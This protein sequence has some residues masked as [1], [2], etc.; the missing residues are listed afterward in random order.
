MTVPYLSRIFLSPMRR[1]TQQLLRNPQRLHAAVLAGVPEQPVCQRVLWRL[2]PDTAR[3]ATLL[4]LTQTLPSWAGLVEQAGW[5]DSEQPQAETRNLETL[6]AR[7]ETGREFAVRVRANPVQALRTPI[8]PSDAQSARLKAPRARG[9]LVAHR[10]AQQQSDW[11]RDRLPCWGFEVLPTGA[12]DPD[13]RLVD[14]ATLRFSVRDKPGQ[15]TLETAMVDARVRITNAGLAR[16][17][18][19]GGV[20]RARAYG[21]GLLTL[22][23]LRPQG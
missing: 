19:T 12:G 14:R 6:L 21:C 3:R 22:A 9:V 7:V 13:L 5:P 23:P 8:K 1:G 15:I 11:F 2:E 10:T 16:S 18:L 20:G 4:V 17:S